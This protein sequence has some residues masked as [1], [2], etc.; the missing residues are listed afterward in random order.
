MSLPVVFVAVAVDGAETRFCR[1]SVSWYHPLGMSFWLKWP[2]RL[3]ERWRGGL[4]RGGA[5]H[6]Q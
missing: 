3:E 4:S 1:G 6:G 2:L 5:V